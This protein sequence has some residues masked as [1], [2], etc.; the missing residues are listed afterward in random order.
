MMIFNKKKIIIFTIC[1]LF[2]TENV[3]SSE[4]ALI[5]KIRF[6]GNSE[7][8]RV[9]IDSNNLIK[10]EISAFNNPS[11]IVV[12]LYNVKFS[13]DFSFPKVTGVIKGI[14]Y[15]EFNA[16]T[17][18][19]VFDLN[20]PPNVN[21]VKVLKPSAG[22]IRRLSFDIISNKKIAVIKNKKFNK[23]YK[24]RKTIVI[25][26]GHGGKDPGTSY[27]KVVSEK[28]IVLRFARIL[29]KNISR[30]NNY[31]IFLTREDDSFVSLSDRVNFAKSK[32]ADLFISIHADAS[33][34]SNTK[35]LS[36]YTLSD[37]GLDKEAEKLAVIENSYAMAGSNYSGNYLRNARNPSDFVKYQR[38]L[39]DNRFKST[40]F[41]STLTS[42]VKS[43]TS[44]LN[45]P[46]RSA[47]FAVL[48]SDEFPSVLVE[49]GFVTN[50][51]DR[52]NLRSGNWLQSISSQFVNA[53]NEYFK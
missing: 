49:L 40:K 2:A 11:R 5:S 33:S 17:S 48:K 22:S 21:N 19:I 36:V 13:E 29:K 42:R 18:R 30:N 4:R 47:G 12:D 28:D 15:A 16:N 45:N 25:D 10:H 7:A 3:F 9:I 1:V 8:L 44:L 51:Y 32:N 50:E 26:P 35:G 24:L 38:K 34:S 52:K 14:R 41:A 31:R 53:I 20:E 27:P 43:K 23:N 46:L 6:S 39:I 37:K